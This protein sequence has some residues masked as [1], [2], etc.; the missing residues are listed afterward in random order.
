[1]QQ[2][3]IQTEEQALA[4]LDL[5]IENKAKVKPMLQQKPLILP[6]RGRAGDYP[7]PPNSSIKQKRKHGKTKG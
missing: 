3:E 7:A 1:M 6:G 4:V 5:L 2:T